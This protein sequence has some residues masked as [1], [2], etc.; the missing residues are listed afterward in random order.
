MDHEN[1]GGMAAGEDAPGAVKCPV[2]QTCARQSSRNAVQA[3]PAG[4]TLEVNAGTVFPKGH[5]RGR[6]DHA[7]QPVTWHKAINDNHGHRR[8]MH[9]VTVEGVTLA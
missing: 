1:P 7:G 4:Q 8:L 2:L 6:Y 3:G 9:R 5:D